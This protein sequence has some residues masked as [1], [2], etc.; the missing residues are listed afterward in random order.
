VA[1][2]DSKHPLG[3]RG[4][5][6]AVPGFTWLNLG[7]DQSRSQFQS[8]CSGRRRCQ[9]EEVVRLRPPEPW[10]HEWGPLRGPL[11]GF[12]AKVRP[13]A[14]CYYTGSG[15]HGG[16][17]APLN[18]RAEAVAAWPVEGSHASNNSPGR[19]SQIPDAR[20]LLCAFTQLLGSPHA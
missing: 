4:A 10:C 17:D 11:T 9:R 6:T 13:S 16:L 14:P 20:L 19:S 7:S 2:T 12:G 5:T 8:G 15:G 1:T 18:G 3:G